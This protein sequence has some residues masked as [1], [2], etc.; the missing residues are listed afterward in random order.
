MYT[1]HTWPLRFGDLRLCHSWNPYS[2]GSL[3]AWMRSDTI[4][5]SWPLAS[6]GF[7]PC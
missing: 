7:A 5:M 2:L 1:S 4:E 6:V 3:G